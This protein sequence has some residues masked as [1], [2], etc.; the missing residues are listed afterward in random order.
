[1][2]HKPR[3]PLQTRK[4][5]KALGKR[6]K[7]NQRTTARWREQNTEFICYLRISPLCLVFLDEQTA[8]PE[9]VIPK[10]KS[11]QTDAHDITKIRAACTFCNELKGSRTLEKL[12]EEFPQLLVLTQHNQSAILE[13]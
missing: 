1:M 2:T 7:A 5:I 4:P 9:H 8:V 6:G 13:E 10:S 12:A 11:S 3:K